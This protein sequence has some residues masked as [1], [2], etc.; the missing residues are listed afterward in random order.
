M[1]SFPCMW[2]G[3][4]GESTNNGVKAFLTLWRL[5]SGQMNM[6]KILDSMQQKEYSLPDAN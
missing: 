2:A 6:L 4:Q 5:I 3:F 1:Q